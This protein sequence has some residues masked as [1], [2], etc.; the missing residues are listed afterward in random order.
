MSGATW[1]KAIRATKT[2]CAL[3]H[4]Y[5]SVPTVIFPDGSVMVELMPNEMLAKL[6]RGPR[7]GLLQRLSG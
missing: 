3:A 4:G 6:N 5:L 1:P 7:P 2:S